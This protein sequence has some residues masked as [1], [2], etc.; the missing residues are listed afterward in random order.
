MIKAYFNE[1]KIY[2]FR[3]DEFYYGC[4]ALYCCIFKVVCGFSIIYLPVFSVIAGHD[5]RMS[6][7]L[8]RDT[9]WH[10]GQV[11]GFWDQEDVFGLRLSDPH[12]YYIYVHMYLI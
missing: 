9:D 11:H 7:M 1:L 6:S 10:S 4:N 8:M 2:L 12:I 5:S 3:L